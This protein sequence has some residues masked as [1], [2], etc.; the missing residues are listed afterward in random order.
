[1]SKY[2]IAKHCTLAEECTA[3]NGY[4]QDGYMIHDE[5]SARFVCEECY[6]ALKNEYP[7]LSSV[8]EIEKSALSGIVKDGEKV[9]FTAGYLLGSRE[10]FNG[11]FK[12]TVKHV[13]EC[14]RGEKGTAMLFSTADVV[15][16]MRFRAEHACQLVGV[17]RTNPSG[18]PS[19][20]SLDNKIVSDMTGDNIYAVIAGNK[21]MQVAVK[22]KNHGE[23]EIG[24]VLV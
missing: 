24:V 12:V 2:A 22:D 23:N 19:F 5:N 4:A 21:E 1:M 8:V 15:R 17:F 11:G 14:D 10:I 18:D 16:L 20:N 6:E 9:M 3:C 7:V 13:L